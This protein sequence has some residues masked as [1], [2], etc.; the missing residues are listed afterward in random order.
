MKKRQYIQHS[1]IAL[2]MLLFVSI[3]S[4]T[5]ETAPEGRSDGII[6][7]SLNNAQTKAGNLFVNEDL[8][9][10]VRI[11]VFINGNIEKNEVFTSGDN[12]FNNSFQV[13]VITGKKEVYVIAN[14]TAGLTPSLAV[15][16]SI[17]QL[18]GL[19]VGTINSPLSLP[20]LM[21]ANI[22]S[23]TVAA[24]QTNLQEIS[25]K[26]IAAKIQLEFRKQTTDDVRIQKVTLLNNTG[27]SSLVENG[28]TISR[29]DQSYWSFISSTG[30]WVLN[31]NAVQIPGSETIYV[32]ENL[33]GGEKAS[34]TQLEVE[35][36]YNGVDTKY[37]VY[38]NENVSTSTNAGNP[39]SSETSPNDHLYSIK[40]NH[41]YVLTGTITKMGEFDGLSLETNVLPWEK[42]SSSLLFD[43]HFEISPEPTST[44]HSY[45]ID[46]SN[47]ISFTFKLTNPPGASWTANL[48]NESD[49]DITSIRN[50]EINQEVTIIVQAKK[51]QSDS[52]IRETELYISALLGGNFSEIPLLSDNELVGEGNRIKIIQSKKN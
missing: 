43:W 7:I 10:K 37:R 9:E 2:L 3:S 6:L 30:D 20:L 51:A 48:T 1:M 35:A 45:V 15:V 47:E 22:P 39:S 18:K 11:L 27:K 21:I 13:E 44:D 28:V 23:A 50:G 42:L 46:S 52:E 24:G 5:S 36:S 32:Y 34:A 38:V 19:L 12:N 26:R 31:E 25:I 49:F 33:T 40:R 8:I 16:S 17:T 29:S 14:E 4:C 41:A